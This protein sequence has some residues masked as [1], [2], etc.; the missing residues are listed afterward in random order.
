MMR[1]RALIQRLKYSDDDF[2]GKI[3]F[4]LSFHTLAMPAM[5]TKRIEELE[6][7]KCIANG[8]LGFIVGF[9][10]EGSTTPCLTPNYVDDDA[11]FRTSVNEAGVVVKRF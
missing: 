9:I 4:L 3:P 5:V 11:Q 1:N 7:I 8:T 10:H 2:T 6:P